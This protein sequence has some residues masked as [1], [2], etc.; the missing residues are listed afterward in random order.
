MSPRI[1]TSITVTSRCLRGIWP[2]VCLAR[3]QVLILAFSFILMI[4]AN[5]CKPANYY[6][7]S[8][9][10]AFREY[11]IPAIKSAIPV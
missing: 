8:Q 6:G 4:F 1:T 9:G 7:A 3:Q 11:N 2:S 10:A 5:K